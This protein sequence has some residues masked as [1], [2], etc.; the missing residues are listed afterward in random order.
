MEVKASPIHGKGLF[1]ILKLKK[2]KLYD[3]VGT[4]MK[5]KEYRGDYRNTYSLKR[6]GKILVGS[7]DNPCQWLNTSTNSNV[8]LKKRALYALRDIDVGEELTLKGYFM[9][10]P[11]LTS[12]YK[13]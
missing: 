5:W 12:V 7:I 9:D 13:E 4:E 8:V 10:Y 2:G 3:Y 6:V 1:A 11:K